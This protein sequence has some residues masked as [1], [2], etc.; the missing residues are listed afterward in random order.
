M[1]PQRTPK[2]R[3]INSQLIHVRSWKTY[4]ENLAWMRG[5][6]GPVIPSCVPERTNGSIYLAVQFS[7]FIAILKAALLLNRQ[8]IMTLFTEVREIEKARPSKSMA[9]PPPTAQTPG[10]NWLIFWLETPHWNTFRAGPPRR[11]SNFILEAE[12]WAYLWGF[13]GSNRV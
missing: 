13:E 10:S 2:K 5:A 4:T 1:A 11:F 8:E 7:F 12:I 6:R 9:P 3:K